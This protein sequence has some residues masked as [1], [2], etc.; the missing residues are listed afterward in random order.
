MVTHQ[1]HMTCLASC[2]VVNCLSRTF[3]ALIL[4]EF[5]RCEDYSVDLGMS[6]GPYLDASATDAEE[7]ATCVIFCLQVGDVNLGLLS[8]GAVVTPPGP[9]LAEHLVETIHTHDFSRHQEVVAISLLLILL[10]R[11]A[12]ECEKL[13]PSFADWWP[14]WLQ[15][16]RIALKIRGVGDILAELRPHLLPPG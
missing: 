16:D 14:V 8:P 3:L 7:I 15:C 9:D 11:P 10:Y 13:L 6:R 2:S 1:L 5:A 4:A 12:K